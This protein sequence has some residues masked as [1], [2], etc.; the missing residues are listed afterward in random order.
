MTPAQ[1]PAAVAAVAAAVVF[2][3][4]VPGEPF[5]GAAR[6]QT[7]DDASVTVVPLE[8]ANPLQ[9]EPPVRAESAPGAR[10]R[11]LDLLTGDTEDLDVT[12]GESLTRGFLSIRLAE[13][14]YPADNPDADAFARLMIVDSRD[15][16]P[17]FDGW[18]IASSPALSA[19]EHPRYDVWVM[20]CSIVDG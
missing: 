17:R 20:A 16:E 14:R 1:M 12:A 10:L 2:A 19:L 8:P 7:G 4:S 9:P 15:D 13:C 18:M 6:A 11:I 3:V 5:R